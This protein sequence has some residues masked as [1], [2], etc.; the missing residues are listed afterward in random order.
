MFA[1]PTVIGT[2]AAVFNPAMFVYGMMA[3]G[4]N[5][6]SIPDFGKAIVAF[7]VRIVVE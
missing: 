6:I 3:F 2:F 5:F 4:H 7:N 1:V